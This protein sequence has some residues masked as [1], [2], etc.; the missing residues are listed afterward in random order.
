[1]GL[2][3]RKPIYKIEYKGLTDTEWWWVQQQMSAGI[4]KLDSEIPED[5]LGKVLITHIIFPEGNRYSM[6]AKWIEDSQ[7]KT[8]FDILLIVEKFEL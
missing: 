1:M 6:T 4:C 5:E 2:N 7:T 3:S 8:T